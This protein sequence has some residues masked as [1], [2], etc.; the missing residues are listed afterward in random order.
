MRKETVAAFLWLIANLNV[1][2]SQSGNFL[3]KFFLFILRHLL[4]RDAYLY[5]NFMI[6]IVIKLMVSFSSDF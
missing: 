6:L 5:I 2:S 1:I 4:N 3:H